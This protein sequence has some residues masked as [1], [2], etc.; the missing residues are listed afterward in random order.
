MQLKMENKIF[1]QISGQNVKIEKRNQIKLIYFF[2]FT[3]VPGFKT[4]M[5]FVFYSSH[6]I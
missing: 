6:D 1:C 4:G 5:I 2:F 3:S